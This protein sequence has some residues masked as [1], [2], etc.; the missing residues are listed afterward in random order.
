MKFFGQT[1]LISRSIKN[2]FLEF[3]PIEISLFKLFIILQKYIIRCTFVSFS[4]LF[5]GLNLVRGQSFILT[6]DIK[7]DSSKKLEDCYIKISS[8]K[9]NQIFAYFNTGRKDT[10]SVEVRFKKGDTFLITATHIGYKTFKISRFINSTD[11]IFISIKMPLIADTLNGVVIKGPPMWVRG[12]TTFFRVN[13]F[14]TGDETKLKDLITKM[15]GFEI[16]ANGNLL[17]K[18][19]LVEK[20]MIDGEE[21]FADK[22]KLMLA[23][24]PVHVLNTVQA[25]ENQTNDRLLK[26]LVN[27]DRVFVNLGLNNE[28]L[29]AVFGDGEAGIG[30]GKKYFFSPVIFSMYG[31]MKLGYIGNWDNIGNGIGWKEQ[32]ELKNDQVRT[33]E[34]WMMQGDQL[35]TINN[36]ESRRYITNGQMGNHF[37]LNIPVSHL[38]KS[39]TEFNLITDNQS[40]LTYNSSSL[41]NGTNYIERKDTNH[42]HNYPYLLTLKHSI[43]WNIDS[44]RELDARISFYHNG[45]SSIKNTDYNQQGSISSSNNRIANNWNSFALSLIY[46]HRKTITKAEKWVASFS[47]HNDPQIASGYSASWPSIF[48][49]PDTSYQLLHQQL[50]NRLTIANASWETIKKTKT[51][52]LTAGISLESLSSSINSSLY[53]NDF[54]NVLIPKYPKGYNNRGNLSVTFLTGNFQKRIKLLKLPVSI[55]AEYGLSEAHR[56]EDTLRSTFTIPVYKLEVNTKDNLSKRLISVFNLSFSQQQAEPYHLYSIL[57]P[58]KINSFHRYLNVDLP[59]R[60]LNSYYSLGYVWSKRNYNYSTSVLFGFSKSYSGFTSIANLNSFASF[61]TDSL[62]RNSTNDYLIYAFTNINSFDNKMLNNL[63]VGMHKSQSFIQH[64]RKLLLSNN[65]FYFFN[66]GMKR[67]W[68]KVY[69]LNLQSNSSYITTQLPKELKNEVEEDVFNIRS[70]LSQRVAISKHSNIVFTTEWYNHNIFTSQ[71]ISFLFMD[72]EFNVTI[73][74]KHLSFIVRF[75]NITNQR[76]Y[77]SWDIGALYQ[78]F[79]TVPLVKR[80]VFLSIRYEL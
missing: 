22:I 60:K 42:I 31:K 8:K 40:Q 76:Y 34:K 24:F 75:Q 73:P 6:G 68:G 30:S 64:N 58:N 79:Y 14:K 50:N 71:Q 77:R 35:Q 57:L 13:G 23:N 18:K 44:V 70:S 15:P 38:I 45:N 17:Y 46:T 41:Y 52:V 65:F 63:S 56:K 61:G 80:N 7:T 25:I 67:N 37:Q 51:G 59:I 11:S 16:D 2:A 54:K 39:K 66:T 1:N 47:Q 36:F 33:A 43:T 62:I 74:Q 28:K 3:F 32:D 53:F 10:F 72:A 48:H 20:I 29:K 21:I 49:L 19:K 5:I 69:F 9:S 78:N 26:G 4:L 12:D 55:K 27:E